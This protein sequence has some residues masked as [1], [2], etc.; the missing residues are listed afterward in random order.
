MRSL[1]S[2]HP[3]FVPSLIALAS[4]SGSLHA[5]D[6]YTVDPA[7]SAALFSINHLDISN[8]HGRFNDISGTLTWEAA[9]PSASAITISIKTESVDSADAKRDQHLRAAD[10]FNSKQFPH[11]TFVSK[12]FTKADEKTYT[13]IGDMTLCGVTKP[14]T[15]TVKKI[16]EGKDPWGGYR[17]GFDSQFTIKRSDFGIKGVPGISDEVQV[18]F[19]LEGIKK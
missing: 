2:F 19:A 9:D 17:I 6:T 14:A 13:V 11:M 8:T 3:S 16:G 5:A 4:L 7:H 12:S 18:T 10:F 1:F 15:V